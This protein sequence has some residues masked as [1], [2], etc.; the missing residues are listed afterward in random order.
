MAKIVELLLE[1][2][3]Q[4][5]ELVLESGS[6][7]LSAYQVAVRNGFIGTEL[8]WL[9]SLSSSTPESNSLIEYNI[10]GSL[11]LVS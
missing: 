11:H 8:E 4:V 6:Q 9:A 1:N 7:G 5:V 2:S 10:D 3:Q